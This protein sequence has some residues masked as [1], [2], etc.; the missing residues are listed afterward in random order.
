MGRDGG[1]V[2]SVLAFCSNNPSFIATDLPLVEM[3]F[4]AD[5]KFSIYSEM[6]RPDA[7][8]W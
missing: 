7:V 3:E 4:H 1:Q 2:V 8:Q 5:S 6:Q